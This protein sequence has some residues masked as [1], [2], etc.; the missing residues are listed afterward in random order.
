[1]DTKRSGANTM[2]LEIF[3][4]KIIKIFFAIFAQSAGICAE[5][6]A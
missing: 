5:K 1:L 6:F 3:L 2:Y 4:L